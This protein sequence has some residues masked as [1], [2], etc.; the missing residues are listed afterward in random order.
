[1]A[2]RVEG[3]GDYARL[4]ICNYLRVSKIRM[5]D[6]FHVKEYLL[7]QNQGLKSSSKGDCAAFSHF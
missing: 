2:D 6:S 1:M 4:Q 5:T 3:R 7:G